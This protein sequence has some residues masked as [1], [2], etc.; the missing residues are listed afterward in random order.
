MIGWE[1]SFDGEDTL[2]LASE[3]L[4][5]GRFEISELTVEE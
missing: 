4:Y 3:L 1:S 2:L 5:W